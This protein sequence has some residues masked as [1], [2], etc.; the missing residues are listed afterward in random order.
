M[1]IVDRRLAWRRPLT[2]LSIETPIP[3]L[4]TLWRTLS[5]HARSSPNGEVILIDDT[6]TDQDRL[7]APA[8]P[9][10]DQ[11]LCLDEAPPS[12]ED[13]ERLRLQGWAR[14]RVGQGAMVALRPN[15]PLWVKP[16]HLVERCLDC[17][18]IGASNCLCGD[19]LLPPVAWRSFIYTAEL[20]GGNFYV[21]ASRTPARRIECHIH[22]AETVWTSRHPMVRLHAL[23]IVPLRDELRLETRAT[24]DLMA[25]HGVSKVRGGK[26][27]TRSRALEAMKLLPRWR[28]FRAAEGVTLA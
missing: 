9:L 28:E 15:T 2:L 3:S 12:V 23:E 17:V 16:F 4:V 10:A 1:T 18:R 5:E 6:T 7:A 11:L 27:Q 14:I 19:A 20:A 13:L 8:M 24:L 25:I 21:G 22:E 26:F